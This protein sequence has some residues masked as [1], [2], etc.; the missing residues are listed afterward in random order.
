MTDKKCGCVKDLSDCS[1]HVDV[2]EY[3]SSVLKAT[4][5]L[6]TNACMTPAS[7]LPAHIR[8]AL[9]KVHPEVISR[10][11]GCGL[12]VPESL[13][14]C[15]I[16][17][18]GSGSGRDCYML[19][20]LVGDKGHVTGIDMTQDLLEVAKKYLDH[21]MKEYGYKTPNVSF[22]Q[23][24]IEALADAG[25]Q[26][27]TF[28]IIISNCVVNLSPD[29]KRVLAEAYSILKNGGELY[30]SDVYSSGRLTNEIKTHKVLWGE[31]IGGALWWEDLVHLA[32][33]VGFS[34]PRL[35]T[36]TIIT[37][38]N[39]ELQDVLGDFRFVAATYRLFKL[40]KGNS[41]PC[42]V[43]YNGGITGVENSFP[44]DCQYTFKAEEVMEV[45]GDLAKILSSSRF[46]GDFTF[47]PSGQGQCGVKAKENLVDPFELVLQLEK[48]NP[49][50]TTR[51]CCSTQS[52][53]CCK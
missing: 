15:K 5:D 18:L 32:E 2:K 13:E 6:K 33:E 27:D 34:R 23:G 45:D 49:G 37:V 51:G 38:D 26:K 41:K 47:E 20:Q 21:H 39:K 3:Y 44:F 11:Y 35:V 42:R 29:K 48:Q 22:V 28:D 7:S 43:I 36:A 50:S 52:A 19:S 53:S 17:D 14:G 12:V 1:I 9:S 16:L 46:A 40:P 4:S 31:C 25:L 8:K 30:F 10:Y 24:Y